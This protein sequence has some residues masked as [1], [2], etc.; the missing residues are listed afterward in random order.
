MMENIV[1]DVVTTVFTAEELVI[2]DTV[3]TTLKVVKVDSN[4][5]EIKTTLKQIFDVDWMVSSINRYEDNSGLER[6]E[7]IV[8]ARISDNAI[9]GIGKKVNDTSKA[10][11][12]ITVVSFDHTPERNRIEAAKENV[13]KMIYDLAQNEV[14]LLNNQITFPGAHSWRVGSIEFNRADLGAQNAGAIYH[15]RAASLEDASAP[16]GG[17][18]ESLDLSHKVNLT[19]TVKL[20]RLVHVSN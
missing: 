8:T 12:K 14:T 15:M 7:A 4:N 17:S 6:I 2:S 19:A 9:G 16:S 3:K 18:S 11:L 20:Q 5:F 10:G 1:Q 13:R